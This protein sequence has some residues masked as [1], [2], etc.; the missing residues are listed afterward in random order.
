MGATEGKSVRNTHTHTHRRD[1][2]QTRKMDLKAK[3]QREID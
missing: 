3:R 2:H 1:I